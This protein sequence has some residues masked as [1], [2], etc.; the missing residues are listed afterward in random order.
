MSL[1][2]GETSSLPVPNEMPNYSGFLKSRVIQLHLTQRC[3]LSCTHCYSS[4]DP[5]K[6]QELPRNW[7]T[8]V[9]A[10]LRCEGYEVICFSG[11]EPLVHKDFISIC[12]NAQLL[13]YKLVTISNGIA[14]N[15]KN[16]GLLKQYL[17]LIGISIDGP[18]ALH[19]S[20]RGNNAFRR[21]MKGIECLQE[22]QIPFGIAHCV[23]RT[24][25]QHLP[26]LL[27]FC[28]QNNAG[29]LQ[30]HPL[31]AVGRGN[32][33]YDEH[34]LTQADLARLYLMVQAMRVQV[35]DQL[36]IQLDVVPSQYL[37]QARPQLQRLQPVQ[38]PQSE[39]HQNSG[40]GKLSCLVNPLII[41]ELGQ[42]WPLAYGMAGDQRIAGG[43]PGEVRS[44]IYHYK[45][46]G[47]ER[48]QQ[49]IDHCFGEEV[50]LAQNFVDWYALAVAESHNLSSESVSTVNTVAL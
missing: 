4:S 23:T 6:C 9:L 33:M 35:E 26:W 7:L 16:V 13:G 37:S 15:N 10:D 50:L 44:G 46:N 14:I 3:N 41:D 36:Q 28:L 47:G 18:E 32:E 45:I 42:L 11:G 49:L 30:L 43:D 48:L 22:A 38:E 40:P 19:N 39:P 17:S 25:L 12:R 8:R 20:L 1:L 27:E 21:T 24:S 34:A 2:K 31:V 29:L 5:Y